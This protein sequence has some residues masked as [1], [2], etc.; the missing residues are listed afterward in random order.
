MFSLK[1]YLIIGHGNNARMAFD[2]QKGPNK[3]QVMSF[4]PKCQ[5]LP[6]HHLQTFEEMFLI[7]FFTYVLAIFNPYSANPTYIYIAYKDA[8]EGNPVHLMIKK[9]KDAQRS[10]RLRMATTT[11]YSRYEQSSRDTSKP[12]SSCPRMDMA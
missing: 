11:A 5:F 6:S 2:L 4:F 10:K 1:S 9:A 8:K 3:M 12:C 7:G